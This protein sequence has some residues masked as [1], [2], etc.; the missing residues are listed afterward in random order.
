[1]SRIGVINICMSL[2]EDDFSTP[3]HIHPVQHGRTIHHELSI[4]DMTRLHSLVVIMN[5]V[6]LK[7][8]VARYCK[9][10]GISNVEPSQPNASHDSDDR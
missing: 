10:R 5:D 9:E 2:N 4:F 1:V 3:T 6:Q 7:G 8:E